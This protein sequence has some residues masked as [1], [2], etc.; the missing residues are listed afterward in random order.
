MVRSFQAYYGLLLE[1]TLSQVI[2]PCAVL[3]RNML[4]LSEIWTP[5][6]SK[7][8]LHGVTMVSWLGEVSLYHLKAISEW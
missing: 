5:E 3:T 2:G 1:H 7:R 4:D 6:Y 8:Q